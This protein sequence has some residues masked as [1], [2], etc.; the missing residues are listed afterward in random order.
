MKKVL[1]ILFVLSFGSLAFAAGDVKIGFIDLQRA[2][3]DSI[4]GQESKAELE[5][6]IVEKRAI[7][8]Q[9]AAER[10]RLQEEFDRQ[11]SVLSDEAARKRIDEIDKLQRDIER[12]V[13]DSEAEV[14]KL[15]REKEIAI[16][17]DLD[18]I[19]SEIGREDNYTMIL[20]AD[21]IIFAAEGVELTDLIIERYNSLKKKPETDT[22]A[23]PKE[24]EKEKTEQ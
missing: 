17:K 8:D 10:Q 4:V 24:N 14:Q 3:N 9:K 1:V 16:L 21:V 11:S 12:M 15:Q 5:N 2:L 20:P 19:I 7:I 23:E 18:A 22:G 6:L 13:A